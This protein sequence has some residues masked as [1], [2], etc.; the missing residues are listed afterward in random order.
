[1]KYAKCNDRVELHPRADWI[2]RFGTVIEKNED[3]YCVKLDNTN[4]I[5]WLPHYLVKPLD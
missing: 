1:M 5:I 3:Q 2:S 4:Q